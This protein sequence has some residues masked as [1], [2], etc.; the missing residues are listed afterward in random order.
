LN[1]AEILPVYL[2]DR[3]YLSDGVTAATN[4]AYLVGFGGLKK[5]DCYVENL[6]RWAAEFV[7]ICRRKLQSL[8]TAVL[9]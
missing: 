1:L 4:T 6:P 5:I 3:L 7:K 8:M 2:V 9:M